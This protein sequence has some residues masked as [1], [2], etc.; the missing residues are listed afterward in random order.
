MSLPEIPSPGS[1]CRLLINAFSPA[2]CSVL[3]TPNHWL[4]H[5][6]FLHLPVPWEDGFV[7]PCSTPVASLALTHLL[8]VEQ[9]VGTNP[10]PTGSLFHGVS[11]AFSHDQTKPHHLRGS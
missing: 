9:T 3:S 2:D 11:E 8:P 6:L 10:A 4:V 7:Y 1:P 5:P